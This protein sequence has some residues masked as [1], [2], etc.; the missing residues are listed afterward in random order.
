MRYITAK[1]VSSA[2]WIT[3][4]EKSKIFLPGGLTDLPGASHLAG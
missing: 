2:L 1:R 3:F 4:S